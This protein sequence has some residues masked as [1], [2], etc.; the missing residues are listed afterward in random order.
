MKFYIVTPT[1]NSL[2]WLQGCVRSVMA[3]AGDGVVVHH[4]IQDGGSGDGTPEWLAEWQAQSAR[5]AGY[6]FTYESAPDKGMYDAI[7]TCWKKMPE[8]AD[9]TAHLNSDEQYLPNVLANVA[10]RLQLHPEADIAL[11]AYVIVDSRGHYICHR[12]PIAPSLFCSSTECEIIT[13]TCFHR[14]ETF[15]KHGIRFDIRWRS[16][17]DLIFYRDIMRTSPRVLVMADLCTSLFSVTGSNL[18]WSPITAKEW[19]EY[20]ATLSSMQ[21]RSKFLVH[22]WCN[23]RRRLRDCFLKAPRE[24]DMY[25][26]GEAQLHHRVIKKP[27]SHWGCREVGED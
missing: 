4:H 3:Q 8:D 17:G 25:R 7:N 19:G 11:G 24:Y 10:R 23:L 2:Q 26:R 20:S 27:T 21:L 1:Y 12:R 9:V 16:I 6:T 5:V 14:A 13:C 22:F 15:R 18:G